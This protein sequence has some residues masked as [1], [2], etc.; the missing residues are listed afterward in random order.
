MFD[1]VSTFCC[2]RFI[3]VKFHI[4]NH[5]FVRFFIQ[6]SAMGVRFIEMILWGFDQKTAGAEILSAL[7]RCLLEHVR[8][9]QVLLYPQTH[10]PYWRID[11]YTLMITYKPFRL[12]FINGMHCKHSQYCF[13]TISHF[14]HNINNSYHKM[15]W[16]CL[17]RWMLVRRGWWDAL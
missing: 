9:R 1:S 2:V 11:A 14:I 6:V 13:L 8:F 10:E 5:F 7:A 4:G 15:L 17:P 3:E 12:P 16:I